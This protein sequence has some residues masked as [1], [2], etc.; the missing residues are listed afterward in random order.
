MKNIEKCSRC[1]S[2]IDTIETP[3]CRCGVI[4]CFPCHE[5]GRGLCPPCA[6]VA[7][8]EAMWDILEAL[9][10]APFGAKR[11]ARALQALF[12]EEP[13]VS[14]EWIN[15]SSHETFADSSTLS[16]CNAHRVD[17]HI[18]ALQKLL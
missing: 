16:E 15:N 2:E 8:A 14:H 9:L 7:K 1:G 17:G 6:S 4:L 11:R 3:R 12:P 18:K 13:V 5:H 10:N